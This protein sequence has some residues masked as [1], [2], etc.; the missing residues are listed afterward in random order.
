MTVQQLRVSVVTEQIAAARASVEAAGAVPPG[1]MQTY[2]VASSVK[3]LAAL[4]SQVQALKLQML[5]E[6]DRRRVAE[7]EA[8]VDTAA[9]A[10]KLCGTMRGIMAGGLRL[11]R[12][13]ETTYEHTRRAFAA[14]RIDVDQV[15]VI[16]NATERMP[17]QVTPEQR[18][19]AESVLVEKAVSGTNAKA[20]RQA[21]RRMLERLSEELADQHE[22]DQLD[23]EEK[24]AE[25]ETWLT[26]QDNGDGTFSGKFVIPELHGHWLVTF[27]ERLTA[28][29][30][31]SRNKA[32]QQVEET[33]GVDLNRWEQ[34]GLALCE[35]IEHLPSKGHGPVAASLN[36]H[37][38]YQHLLDGLG[39]ARL[40]TGVRISAGEARRLACSAGV[41]PMVFN[42]ASLPLDVG[43]E[44]RL[45]TEA[46]RKALS[47]K[48]DSCAAEGCDRP[49]AWCEI[50][51]VL[52]WS[53]GGPTNVDNGL[54]LCWFHHRRAHDDRYT[55]RHLDT[56][57][58]RYRRR[59]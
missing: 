45:H 4:E 26:L 18:A 9:W 47:A 31:L 23:D 52:P 25:V 13:L 56:G 15:R 21:A 28:P 19:V 54:P 11:A 48:H 10:A 32:G 55:V 12:L 14:G 16:V 8:D 53:R 5:V 40:D 3:E 59:R 38:D 35:L 57:E 20:L 7:G 27:L 2:E 46:Q 30:R 58:V 36:V 44:Q 33:T 41:V 37:L 43:R 24:R 49:F 39:S 50:H 51:H 42:G 22:K 1:L 29:R 34:M 6:A 17:A